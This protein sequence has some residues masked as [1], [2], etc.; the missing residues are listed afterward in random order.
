MPPP[1]FGFGYPGNRCLTPCNP[2]GSGA[3]TGGTTTLYANPTLG[4]E[5]H[6]LLSAYFTHDAAAGEIYNSPNS[7][8]GGAHPGIPFESHHTLKDIKIYAIQFGE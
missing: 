7:F 8:R 1:R 2:I 4:V 3:T 5:S 6:M